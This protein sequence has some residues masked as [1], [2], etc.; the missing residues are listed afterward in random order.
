MKKPLNHHKIP[1]NHHIIRLIHTVHTT[2]RNL[3][4]ELSDPPAAA[5]QSGGREG[6]GV[7]GTWRRQAM[8][9]KSSIKSG[10]SLI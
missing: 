1:L 5:Q 6:K 9:E 4:A 2:P 7:A 8:V 3:G 10:L